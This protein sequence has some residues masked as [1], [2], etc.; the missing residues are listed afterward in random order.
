MKAFN[1]ELIQSLTF[2]LNNRALRPQGISW[3]AMKI[4][5]LV[6]TCQRRNIY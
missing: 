6:F 2:T 4:L 3:I 5:F 1:K